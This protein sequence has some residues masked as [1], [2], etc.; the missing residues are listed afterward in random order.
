MG[1]VYAD[2]TVII[3]SDRD[4]GKW[5]ESPKGPYHLLPSSW[6]PDNRTIALE[7]QPSLSKE[8]ICLLDTQTGAVTNLTTGSI[9][10]WTMG[11]EHHTPTWSPDGKKIAYSCLRGGSMHICVK[12]IQTGVE[13]KLGEGSSPAW[14][15]DGSKIAFFDDPGEIYV[16]DAKGF[17]RTR[18]TYWHGGGPPVWTPSDIPLYNPKGYP[19]PPAVWAPDGSKI[20]FRV[21]GDPADPGSQIAWVAVDGSEQRMVT[22]ATGFLRSIPSWGPGGDKIV[23]SS[24]ESG[25]SQPVHELYV[26]DARGTV[27]AKPAVSDLPLCSTAWAWPG[28]RPH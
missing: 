13:T 26:V 8:D 22:G 14:S 9:Q 4:A 2:E 19:S 25:K 5:Y 24:E 28:W 20:A 16:M 11:I 12:D 7:C 6:S 1:T 15:P 23:F 10:G 21:L 3:W 17:N 18:L 27:I